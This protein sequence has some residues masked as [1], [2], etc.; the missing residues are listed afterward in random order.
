[1]KN[2]P[3][4]EKAT[5]RRWL[6]ILL[7]LW[8]VFSLVPIVTRA[9]GVSGIKIREGETLEELAAGEYAEN[10]GTIVTNNGTVTDNYGTVTTNNGTGIHNIPFCWPSRVS[11]FLLRQRVQI[12]CWNV[13]ADSIVVPIV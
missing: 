3:F 12:G 5:H 9:E 6:S 8:M 1:M 13:F 4:V 11:L 10:H 7:I 2:R